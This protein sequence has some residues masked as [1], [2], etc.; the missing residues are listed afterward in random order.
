MRKKKTIKV[1]DYTDFKLAEKEKNPIT[2]TDM[3]SER[4]GCEVTIMTLKEARED[5]KKVLPSVYK[6]EDGFWEMVIKADRLKEKDLQKY[7]DALTLF[8]GVKYRVVSS[9]LHKKIIRR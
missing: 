4:K 7:M 9:P 2:W 6:D 3:A 8:N 5:N 1:W